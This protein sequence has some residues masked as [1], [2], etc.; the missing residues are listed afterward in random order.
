MQNPNFKNPWNP[1]IWKYPMIV[2]TLKYLYH[3]LLCCSLFCWDLSPLTP[4]PDYSSRKT[5]RGWWRGKEGEGWRCN[6]D[7]EK[8]WP[9]PP[10]KRQAVTAVS[11][12]TSNSQTHTNI[13]LRYF[14]RRTH[15]YAFK[16]RWRER[17]HR[18]RLWWAKSVLLEV[19]KDTR[20]SNKPENMLVGE[21]KQEHQIL[22][23]CFY[24]SHL[25]PLIYLSCVLLYTVVTIMVNMKCLK[26]CVESKTLSIQKLNNTTMP[27]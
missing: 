7:P 2:W 6:T 5:R 22:Q 25:I 9:T 23:T 3:S 8:S 24:S 16:N 26:K 10:L 17:A 27:H 4:E 20:C 15:T 18:Q 11:H 14:T 12:N 1:K 13:R 21:R 19:M